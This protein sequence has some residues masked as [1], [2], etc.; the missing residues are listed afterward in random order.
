MLDEIKAFFD[1]LRTPFEWPDH[2]P[3]IDPISGVNVRAHCQKHHHLAMLALDKTEFHLLE[4]YRAGADS[5]AAIDFLDQVIAII[6]RDGSAEER[7]HAIGCFLR[8]QES[9]ISAAKA[10]AVMIDKRQRNFQPTIGTA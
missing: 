8:Q 5:V 2:Y 1:E 4:I 7:M 6:R 10:S 3:S 9:R